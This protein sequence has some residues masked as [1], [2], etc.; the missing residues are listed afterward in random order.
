MAYTP[1]NGNRNGRVL[2]TLLLAAIVA[3][4]AVFGGYLW[5]HHTATAATQ[6]TGSV[7]VPAVNVA[8]PTVPA[9]PARIVGGIPSGFSH[10]RNGAIAAGIGFLQAVASIDGGL[11]SPNAVQTQMAAANPSAAVLKE[12]NGDG[13]SNS[14]PLPAG[15]VEGFNEAPIAVKV[16]AISATAAQLSFWACFSGGASNAPG[17]PINATFGCN[18]ENVALSWEK[19]D[20]KIADYLFTNGGKQSVFELTRSNGYQV[21]VGSYTVLAVG[22]P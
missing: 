9:G 7:D 20:W 16:I 15:I 22:Q 21:L 11:S 13:T 19:G 14:A 10:D 4:A 3:V 6:A 1:V 18:L 8:V 2:L 17:Q 12:I 5:G